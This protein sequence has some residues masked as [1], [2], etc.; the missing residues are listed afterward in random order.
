[1]P[2]TTPPSGYQWTVEVKDPHGKPLATATHW[3]IDA[4]LTSTLRPYLLA[5]ATI[6]VTSQPATPQ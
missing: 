1:M 2:V 6:T 4:L 5:G 3:D